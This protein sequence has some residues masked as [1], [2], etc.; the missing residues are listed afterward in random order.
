MPAL[1][2]SLDNLIKKRNTKALTNFF[3]DLHPFEIANLIVNRPK[4]DYPLIFSVLPPEI[5]LETFQYLP[6]RPQKEV[7][8]SMSSIQATTLLQAL[9]PDDRT[10]FLQEL[11]REV[12]D[13][14]VKIL[15]NDERILTLTLLGYPEGSIGRLMTPDYIA[16]EMDWT[17]EK[18]LDHI[19]AYGHYSEIID[20]IYVINKRGKLLDDLN[21]K[22]ILFIPRS[23]KVKDVADNQFVA[24][25]VY[26]N[27]ETAINAFNNHNRIALP[28]VDEENI[29][30]GIVTIDDILNLSN[31]EATEDIQ[32][33]GGSQALDEPYMQV[34][35]LKLMQ[36]R[37]G[38][39]VILFIGEMFTATALSYF[40]AEIDKAVVLALFLPLIIS[41]G[42]NAGSQASTLVIRALSLGEINMQDCWKILK[43]E[44]L[45][46]IFLGVILGIIG[47][48]RVALWNFFLNIYGEYWLKLAMTV[49]FSLVGVILWGTLSGACFPFILKWAKLDP[50]TASAPLVATIVDVAGVVIYFLIAISVLSGTLL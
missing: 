9:P 15:P 7:L 25:S 3:N 5:A 35:F 17:I 38:W 29:L 40:E 20:V 34:P 28:V 45:A 11:P 43:R 26:D 6:F 46:G 4:E 18:V 48:F 24:L 8:N 2:S 32:K 49:G 1:D 39:L 42:G 22:E 10:N 27:E 44:L 16:V 21:L 37:A 19:Q 31:E 13:E 47:F 41:S 33:I 36:K 14:F 50:A 12:I 30:L 23:L